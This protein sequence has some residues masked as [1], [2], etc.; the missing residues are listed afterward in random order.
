MSDTCNDPGVCSSNTDCHH[1]QQCCFEVD[2]NTKRIKRTL[3]VLCHG[4]TI[5]KTSGKSAS[6]SHKTTLK[7]LDFSENLHIYISVLLNLSVFGSCFR[8]LAVILFQIFCFEVG[9]HR[10]PS[11]HASAC[12]NVCV[13]ACVPACVRVCVSCLC[14]CLCLCVCVSVY[15]PVSMPVSM[16]VCLCVCESVSMCVCV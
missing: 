3:T 8:T 10:P 13:R 2:P 1:S 4:H 11:L 7:L 6:S 9:T 5:C 14:L 15:V 12:T 16:S